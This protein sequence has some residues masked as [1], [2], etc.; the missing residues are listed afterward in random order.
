MNTNSSKANPISPLTCSTKLEGSLDFGKENIKR[1]LSS[2]TGQVGQL[3]CSAV[4]FWS[5]NPIYFAVFLYSCFSIS[6][7]EEEIRGGQGT[8]KF[9]CCSWLLLPL[10]WIQVISHIPIDFLILHTQSLGFTPYALNPNYSYSSLPVW[11]V[12]TP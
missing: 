2:M 6:E 12:Q 3:I 4:S 10:I 1:L 11:T 7:E 9:G 8:T 5:Y